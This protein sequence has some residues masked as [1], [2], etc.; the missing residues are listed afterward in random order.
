METAVREEV[1]RLATVGTTQREL[2]RSI[3][4]IETGF[5]DALQTVG[6]FGGKADRLN[7]YEFYVGDPG[8]VERDLARYSAITTD[9][10]RERVRQHIAGHN[11]VILSVVP[12]GERGLAAGADESR[13]RGEREAT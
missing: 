6:G 8:F 3:N 10:L 11:A 5:V 4:G 2:E 13:P 7:L 1:E 9:A 12:R